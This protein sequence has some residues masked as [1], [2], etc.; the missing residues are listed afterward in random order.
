MKGK[1]WNIIEYDNSNDTIINKLRNG[2]GFIKEYIEDGILNILN[3][4]GEYFN[5][6]RNGKGKEFYDEDKVKFEGEYLNGERNGK[7]KEYND[8]GKLIFEGE[9]VNGIKYN[10]WGYDEDNGNKIYELKFGKG[11]IKEYKNNILIYEGKLEF[12]G[13]YLNGKRN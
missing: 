8:N 12:E 3:Y 11:C 9:Y 10:G 5:G 2:K 4:E 7:G 6:E 13:D 1:R